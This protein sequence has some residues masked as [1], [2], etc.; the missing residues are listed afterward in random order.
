MTTGT[1]YS[2]KMERSIS[3]Y[4]FNRLAICVGFM[5]MFIFFMFHMFMFIYVKICSTVVLYGMP[6]CSFVSLHIVE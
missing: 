1:L 3:V 5:S 6:F 4:S 2:L